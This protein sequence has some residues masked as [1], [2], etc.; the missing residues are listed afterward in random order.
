MR[1]VMLALF[2]FL[3]IE[4]ILQGLYNL[5]DGL[6]WLR[7]AQRRAGTHSGFYAPRV[8]LFCPVKGA[9]PGLEQNISALAYF[10]Y[11]DY[12]IFF[13]MASGDDPARKIVERLTAASKHKIHIVI[14]GRP[15]ECG[16][17]VNNLRAAI[18]KATEGFD[19]YVFADSDGRPGRSWLS[20]LVAPLV[21]SN[22]GAVTAFRWFFR[23]GHVI[24]G[25][26][27]S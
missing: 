21:D 16:E 9:E 4:Q 26:F 13:T 22:L 10:D 2:Y 12:E 3:V 1:K 20:R 15:N 27:A 8:A 6:V 19:V 14:A 18:L 11:P 5:W 25:A 7:L 24:W 17:K 23:Q